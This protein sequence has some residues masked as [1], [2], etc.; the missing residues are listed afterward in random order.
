MNG[1]DAFLMPS[2][3]TSRMCRITDSIAGLR[4]FL[5][6]Y[7]WVG[8]QV[9][10]HLLCRG[11]ISELAVFTHDAPTFVPDLRMLAARRG[12]WCTTDSIN[13]MAWPFQPDIVASV[14]YRD[15]IKPH[16]IEHANRRI[17]NLHPS[18]LPRHRGCSSLTWAIIDGDPIT[19]VTFHY[20]DPG[21]DSGS[22]ILQAALQISPTETQATLYQR[23]MEL[24]TGFWPAAF[25]LVRAGFQGMPQAGEPTCHRREVPYR[26][27]IDDTWSIEKVERFIRAMTY[28]PYPY[29]TYH[30]RQI[31]TLSEYL[32]LRQCGL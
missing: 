3:N 15:I 11:D 8:C 1:A 6:G 23:A 25:E 4:L 9:L 14:Y 18:L 26:G 16:V 17:F 10:E 13:R 20:I 29:A 12:V 21:I 27:E 22:I 19:G 31:R 24:G 5:C 2:G 30:G 28:P 7:H 32:Q